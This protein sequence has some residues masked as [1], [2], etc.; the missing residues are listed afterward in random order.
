MG[1]QSVTK[2]W[3]SLSGLPS[4]YPKRM[5]KARRGW[6]ASG[7]AFT[8][9]APVAA[10]AL[11]AWATPATASWAAP[12]AYEL[13]IAGS[14][15]S[16]VAAVA[17]SRAVG[18]A[19]TDAVIRIAAGESGVARQMLAE[20][21]GDPSVDVAVR[22]AEGWADEQGGLRSGLVERPGR[23]VIP[24]VVDG[25]VVARIG[26]S[27]GAAR[28]PEVARAIEAAGVLASEN[29]DLRTRLKGHHDQLEDARRRLVVV[30]DEQRISLSRRLLTDTSVATG[31]MARRLTEAQVRAADSPEL[32]AALRDTCGQHQAV[33]QQLEELA[34]GL[35]PNLEGGLNRTVVRAAQRLG[36]EVEAD[37]PTDPPPHLHRTVYFVCMEALSNVAKHSATNRARVMCHV[38]GG[39]LTLVVVDDGRGGAST[40]SGTGLQGIA[41]RVAALGGSCTMRSPAGEGTIVTVILPLALAPLGEYPHE[42]TRRHGSA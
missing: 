25:D 17:T 15:V 32:A 9:G 34:N 29:A 14:A 33:Q 3:L 11:S 35:A 30:E 8:A 22:V 20:A 24:V 19:V 6:A 28:R 12:S 10:R 41:D 13:L 36:L 18:G 23:V 1:A 2:R 5:G 4:G 31:E 26:C 40:A 21:L 7:I 27:E 42:P 37:I 39:T 38:A 16:I